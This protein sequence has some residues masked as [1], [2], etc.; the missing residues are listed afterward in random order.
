[1]VRRDRA[2]AAASAR[3]LPCAHPFAT[4]E[5][6]MR[7]LAA[8]LIGSSLA[9]LVGVANASDTERYRV[10]V[11]N[12]TRGQQFTP[13]LL[14]THRASLRLFRLGRPATPELA[15][16]AEEGDV[17]P[18]KLLLDA[19]PAVG[20]TVA[21]NSLTDPGKSATFTIEARRGFDRLSVAAM[22]IPT[23]DAFVAVN[24]FDLDEADDER[25]VTIFAVAYDAG[26]EQNDELCSSIPGPKF[27]ECN[28]GPGGGAAVGKGE[29][30]VHIHNGIHGIGNMNAANR[31]WLNPVA[32]V[33][34]RRVR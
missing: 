28:N 24:G 16:L 32:E 33:R 27:V 2:L 8:V 20:A 14:A 21:G 34:I 7:H 23:N 31:T 19:N 12:I 9:A 30:F 10:T 29:G 4:V 11:T 1:M 26:S 17:G 3:S 6:D 18:L 25:S 15:T 5:S 13:L 22:L